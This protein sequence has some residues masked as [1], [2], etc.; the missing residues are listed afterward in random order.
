L[1]R[2]DENFARII[3]W[4]TNCKHIQQGEAKIL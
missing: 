2:V 4:R 3:G 1:R